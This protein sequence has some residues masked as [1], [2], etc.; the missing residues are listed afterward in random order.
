MMKKLLMSL[1]LL[2]GLTLKV[3]AA[4]LLSTPLTPLFGGSETTLGKYKGKVM[5][6]DVWAS[7][8]IPCR[9]S[10]PFYQSLKNKYG[11]DGLV[12]VSI[13]N[14]DDI[15]AAKQFY[16]SY[17]VSFVALRDAN[18]ALIS[19]LNPGEMPTSFILDRSGSIV[20]TH[21]GFRSGDE[22]IIENKVKEL[23]GK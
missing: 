6:I 3:E 19:Q 21:N 10:F 23:L 16:N 12:I 1:I 4:G 2:A 8:C 17:G 14:E 5:L 13:N 11:K 22:A 7:W 18:N 15:E 20:Y 9:A